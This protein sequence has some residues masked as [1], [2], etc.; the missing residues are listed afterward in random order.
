[1][2]IL[3][4]VMSN[5][6]DTLGVPRDA[7]ETAIK[8]A[9][10]ALSLKYHPDRNPAPDAMPKFQ[11]INEAYE[12]LSDP[13]RRA[14]YDAELNGFRHGGM[15]MMDPDIGNIFNMMFGGH[16]M[17]GGGIHMQGMPGGIHVFHMGGDGGGMFGG[18]GMGMGGMDHI[19]RQIHKPPSIIQNVDISFEQAFHGCTLHVNVEKW[20]VRNDLKI[21]E[22]EVM[23]LTVPAGIDHEEV[24]VLR[25]CGNTVNEQMKG[26]VKFI[27]RVASH[28]EFTRHGMDLILK[29]QLS[30][31]EALT[32]F[33]FE[34]VHVNGKMLTLNNKTKST[35]ISPNYKKT[36]PGLGMM[37]DNNKGNLIIEFDV[38]FPQSLTSEQI[39]ALINIL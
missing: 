31:K 5:H 24:I 14:Q 15:P 20:T 11:A 3:L 32:G 10:R 1:V 2:S 22:I 21:T 7:D 4:I 28:P 6:Y 19:F 23:Y 30:L 17:G 27:V 39:D 29:K 38:V 26:D 16:G 9:F 33:S 37:R 25:D 12:H 8:K 35:V 36:I 13:Q 34:V 18:P